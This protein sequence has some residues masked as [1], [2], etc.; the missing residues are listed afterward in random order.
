VTGASSG[1][2]AE[3]ARQLAAAGYDLILV[4]RRRDRLE[5]LR[6]TLR[7]GHG[8]I[9]DV[10]AA[11]LAEPQQRRLVETAA[12]ERPL[13]MLVNNAGVGGILPFDQTS[14]DAIQRMLDVNVTALTRLARAALPG[15]LKR[16]LGTI[17]NVGSGLSF[18]TMP[19]AAVYAG[20][21]AYVVH[22]TQA[23][24][25]EV[26][27]RGIRLQALV[28]GLVRTELGSDEFYKQFPREAVMSPQALVSASLAGLELGELVCIPVLADI[29]E[30]AAAN[31]AIRA[32]GERIAG[33]CPAVP[34]ARYARRSSQTP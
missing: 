30:W 10:I 7:D 28:P 29:E 32:V 23:L 31:T 34:A 33:A 1:I 17:V 13:S 19:N 5:R 24:G 18:T 3:Y 12:A 9:V 25:E 14:S 2:G 16:G 21:K 20:T 4:A 6:D 15:M 8:V 27:D 22:F 26:A 11:D